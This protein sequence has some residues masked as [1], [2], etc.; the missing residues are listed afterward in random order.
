MPADIE[1]L[2]ADLQHR[3]PE[4]MLEPS[5]TRIASVVDLLGGP[6]HSFP[7]IHI[8]GTN[9]KTST[10]RMMESLL[11]ASGLRTGLFTSPH[12][13]DPAERIRVDGEPIDAETM[14]AAW[15]DIQPYVEVVDAQSIADGGPA[16]SFFEVMTALA[17]AV[18][19]DAPVDVAVIEVGMGGEWDATNV[20]DG[21][22]A[23]LTPVDLDHQRYLGDDVRDIAAEKVGIIKAD[24]RVVTAHQTDDVAHV[25]GDRC[26]DVHATLQIEGVDFSLDS[27]APAVG[28][29]LLTMRIGSSIY[30]DVF[31]PLFGE[32]QAHN[33]LL[34][35]AAVSQ[36]L[37]DVAADVVEEGFRT[38]SS[39]GRLQI[40]RRNPAV[41]VDAAH[42]PHGLE[43]AFAAIREAVDPDPLIV[44]FGVLDDKDV[45]GM[46]RIIAAHASAVVIVEPQS[47]RALPAADVSALAIDELGADRVWVAESL[48]D[49]IDR[50][51]GLA[52]VDRA[53]G[54]GAVLITG[55]VVLVGDA[56]RMME[57]RP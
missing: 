38:T 36:L 3:W 51:V 41:V 14:L 22:V 28:G 25:I 53:Y 19:A 21:Q 23:V 33:A 17:F 15:A 50:A 34:A 52:E 27:R 30:A 4:N 8:T 46:M 56:L 18:F 11:R 40:L 12:L 45:L 39:P 29:Q 10:A 20:A 55:S 13:I 43:H 5:L 2:W 16:M 44:I 9:G 32:H 42:N 1:R 49:A 57:S 37:G 35:L 31:I 26:R 48:L 47:T 54:G 7:V 24:A 6:Q